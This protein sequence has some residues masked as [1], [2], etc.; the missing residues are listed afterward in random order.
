MKLKLTLLLLW[1]AAV[2]YGQHETHIRASLYGATE[3]LDIKQ[4][5]LVVNN[6]DQAWEE[7]YLMDWA[8]A[9]SSVETPLAIRFAED[10]K[11]RFQFSSEESKG[12]T[13]FSKDYIHEDYR[14][15]RPQ[16]HP[17]VV[18][19]VLKTPIPAGSSRTLNLA[20]QVRIPED[21]FTGYGRTSKDEY[22]LRYW[23]L[24]PAVFND[25]KWEYYSH[26][27][28]NDFHGATTRFK[29]DL[30]LPARL[31]AV[32]TLQETSEIFLEERN[33][34]QFEGTSRREVRLHLLRQIDQYKNYSVPGLDV[35]T[36]LEDNDVPTDMKLIFTDRIASFL[37]DKLGS[38][39]RE[40]LLISKEFYKENPVYGLSSLPSFI[41][42]F[43]AGFTYEVQ[44]LKS[45]TRSWVDEGISV[46]PRQESWLQQAIMV[47]LIMEYQEEYYPNLKIGGKL[48]DFWG[49]R[50]FKAS[51]LKFNDRFSL[52]YLNSSR[53]NL[54]QA[55][56]TPADE[57][58]KYNQQLGIPYKAAIG[59][60]ILKDYLGDDALDKSLRQLYLEHTH[61]SA[62]VDAFQRLL[63][64]NASKDVSWFFDDYITTY[65]R[66]D[67]KINSIRKTDDSIHFKLKNKSGIEMP[68]PVYLL[69][70]DSIIEKKWLEIKAMDS[71]I[72][73]SRK[74][75]N[76]IALN[77]ERLIPE[78]NQ[79]DNYRTLKPLPSLNRP[80]EFR[81]FKDIEDP[82]RAQV[83]L[84]PD[85][86]FNIYDGLTPGA[87]FY[88]G[89]L[90]PKPFRYSIKPGYG[91]T[92]QK[93]V[94]S[95]GFGY[96]HFIDNREE[97]LYQLRYGLSANRFS[98]ADDLMF[99]RGSG[100][101]AFGFRPA[102]LRSNKRSSL[103]F[104]NIFV[105][106][107]RDPANPVNE[108]DYNVF[109]INYSLS[110]NNLK[111]VFS[112]NLGTEVSSR[113]S[114]ATFRIK[115]R[116]LYK[117]NRQLELRFFSGLFLHNETRGSDNFF[118]FALDRPTDYLFDYNYYGRSEDDGLFSQQLIVAEGGFK[119]QLE[120]AF[121]D[122]WIAT[123]NASY[124][125]WNY[126]HV[127]GDVGFVKNKDRGA[128][129]VY[130]SGVRLNL[131]QDYFELYFPVY[132]NN[133]WEIA[134]D[135][136]DEKIRF[137]VTLDINTFIRLFT[138]R[139]Y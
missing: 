3:T 16:D 139:W 11:N 82:E 17:D 19:L 60:H 62:T 43:P 127:Y 75:A 34:Y 117:N 27:S 124:S 94:G 125:L 23:Y 115:Y 39:P 59:L 106:R 92:S 128:K 67:W 130:D 101:L 36:N 104:R 103:S 18:R 63:E 35:L 50:G 95:V 51:Q 58:V 91:L 49:I 114:K 47:Y 29:I 2:V 122:Q 73:L 48:S 64:Q 14:I 79:R 13:I 21:D 26:K 38:F 37:T 44:L 77:Y 119:S 133:G 111:R 41:N 76:R 93:I 12:R 56:N 22:A 71:V 5:L 55:A 42:P 78:F 97:S 89:N 121:A 74:R 120:P 32:S 28:I 81:L 138:R 126:I 65:K 123:T 9:F 131:L 52:L 15:E 105:D 98:Y 87:R 66:L 109:T 7:V 68:V 83:F 113:F 136:Y 118:S 57:L 31:K 4:E 33:T 110:D 132:S 116:K 6:S 30:Q 137:I 85:F 108:P 20:Y 129:F 102:D 10:F 134:Q 1:M 107:D 53:L 46:N 88:N 99:R 40:K 61:S 69:D 112:Y 8:N 45:M 24:H 86:E 54:D 80:L 135:N 70:K 72:S 84:M 25:G 96:T 90:L 100:W